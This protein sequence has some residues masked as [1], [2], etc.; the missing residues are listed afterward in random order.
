MSTL[1]L[2][3]PES[4]ERELQARAAAQ[5]RHIS[6]VALELLELG[7]R[8]STTKMASQLTADERWQAFQKHMTEVRSRPKVQGVVDDSRE[9]IYEGRGE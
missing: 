9:S 6:S 8:D 3:V 1:I 2:S 7:L 4:L 5:G